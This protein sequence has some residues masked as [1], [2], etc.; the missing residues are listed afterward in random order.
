ML[1]AIAGDI[2]GAAYEG[3]PI[4]RDDLDLFDR[5]RYFTDDTVLT[6]ATADASRSGASLSAQTKLPDSRETQSCDTPDSRRTNRSTG[7][8]SRTSLAIITPL[9]SC[10]ISDSHCTRSASCG[11]SVCIRRFCFS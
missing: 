9:K 8:A 5:P 11:I 1:G 2:F 4:K 6:V 3:N 10:G 7:R